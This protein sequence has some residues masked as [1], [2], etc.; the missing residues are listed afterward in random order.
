MR[1]ASQPAAV[2]ARLQIRP[3]STGED[4]S[5]SVQERV[6][7][8]DRDLAELE[9]GAS[10]EMLTRGL[11]DRDRELLRLRFEED[12]TQSDI[13]ERVGLSQMHVSRLLRDALTRLSDELGALRPAA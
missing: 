9:H 13:A 7:I 5:A 6:G 2:R 12:L 4:D 11:G 3:L 10:L 8:D 1:A